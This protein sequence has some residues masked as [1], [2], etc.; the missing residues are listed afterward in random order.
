M[1]GDINMEEI[2]FRQPIWGNGKFIK[3]Y[4]W[5]YKD[6]LYQLPTNQHESYQYTGLKDK[7]GK[8]IYEGDKVCVETTGMN[9]RSDRIKGTVKF[10][11]GCFTVCF[12]EEV[13][14]RTLG[15]VRN[16]LYVKC[17]VVNHAIWVI[18]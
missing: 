7:N 10:I 5:G 16:N 15:C 2:K 18:P 13:F 6:G 4:Y 1:N 17:F 3:W 9:Y 11:D 14:D 12:D 8:E